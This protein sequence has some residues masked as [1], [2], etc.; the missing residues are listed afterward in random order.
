MSLCHRSM[1]LCRIFDNGINFVSFYLHYGLYVKK[2]CS[3]EV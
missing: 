2:G 1:T 3:E